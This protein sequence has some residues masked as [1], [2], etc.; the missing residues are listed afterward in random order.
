MIAFIHIYCPYEAIISC[1]KVFHSALSKYAGYISS[2]FHKKTVPLFLLGEFIVRFAF[3]RF[4][5]RRTSF[6]V[7]QCVKIS[8]K[9]TSFSFLLFYFYNIFIILIFGCQQMRHG[10][11]GAAVKD[12]SSFSENQI[13]PLFF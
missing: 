11:K 5:F 4:L 10:E 2:F 8:L 6:S 13:F 7:A 1:K 3:Y 9:R 12:S